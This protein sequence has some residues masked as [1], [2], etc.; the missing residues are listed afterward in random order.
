MCG[1]KPYTLRGKDETE[2]DFICLTT[3][4]PAFSWFEIVELLVTTDVIIPMGTEGQNGIRLAT[5]LSYHTLT[6]GCGG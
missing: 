3:I 2:I 1:S 4:N 6:R 5:T